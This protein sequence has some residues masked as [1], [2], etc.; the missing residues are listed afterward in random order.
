MTRPPHES[1]PEA[2]PARWLRALLGALVAW[3]AV[4]GALR[5][6]P[7]GHDSFQ[8][9][10][11][12]FYFL[13]EAVERGD[14][15]MWI[16]YMTHGVV[17]TWWYAIVAE[18]LF[19]VFTLL[20]PWL[21][22]T[23]L[24]GYTL[25]SLGFD[26]SVLLLGTWLL[27]R[28]LF[29]RAES[30]AVS[31][32]MI[33]GASVWITQSWHNLHIIY[34]IPLALWLVHRYLDEHR[35]IHLV[36]ALNLLALQAIGNLPYSLPPTTLFVG[37][38][39]IA[40][41]AFEGRA[42]LRPLFA[43]EHLPGLLVAAVVGA[44]GMV[45]VYAMFSQGTREIV[46]LGTGRT[47]DGSVDLRVFLTYGGNTSLRKWFELF[48][49]VSPC[50]DYTLYVG[51]LGVPL[52]VLGA[53]EAGRKNAHVV[54][55]GA[56]ILA[57]S[58]ATP[59][60]TAAYYLWPGMKFFR[61]LA[62]LAPQVKVAVCLLAGIGF[63]RLRRDLGAGAAWSRAT[64]LIVGWCVVQSVVVGTLLIERDLRV[65]LMNNMI[66][67]GGIPANPPALVD[68]YVKA[69]LVE[70]LAMCGLALTA[71]IALRGTPS[72]RR[73]LLPLLFALLA[74]D[75]GLFHVRQTA[76]MSTRL[77]GP[78]REL[79]RATPLPYVARRA[80]TITSAPRWRQWER[81][82]PVRNGAWYWSTGLVTFSDEV[83]ST[84]R[85]DNWL[86]P[87]GRLYNAFLHQPFDR[88]GYR[89]PGLNH[90][91]QFPIAITAPAMRRVFGMEGKLRVFRDAVA[92]L[93]DADIAAVI[94]RDD[95]HGDVL[96]LDDAGGIAPRGE[97][98]SR[99]DALAL[100][101][102]V[103]D[104]DA[105]RIEIR[106]RHVPAGGAWLLYDD[107]WHPGW[108]ASVNG[109][110]TRV[111]RANLAYKSVRL[112]AGDNRVEMRFDLPR[113]RLL[114]RLFA[115]DAGLWIL[116]VMWLYAR[117]LR[118]RADYGQTKTRSSP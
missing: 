92:G 94:Q 112:R 32:V 51:V 104:F 6:F 97:V 3:F 26:L 111:Y 30:A 85:I 93:G 87:V 100:T 7:A 54:I 117:E 20:G 10:T 45:G 75:V 56:V 44:L 114:A 106:V 35:S 31:C 49:G 91:R 64:R 1:E 55:T 86:W 68:A 23:D 48:I 29:A 50:I 11:T 71:V 57:V 88:T 53:L 38:Y 46:H 28:R 110:P 67:P 79:L 25:A 34:A 76:L 82:S 108:S 12:Q 59:V 66:D 102:E 27:A 61:H 69:R 72:R 41:F 115:L 17:A 89:P 47:A 90:I 58:L 4:L 2:R 70:V 101:P 78:A 103:L 80:D 36:A 107:A 15:A 62:L 109:A 98:A 74:L 52:A 37:V 95:Y 77:T 40:W 22:R 16:P 73:A 19:Q 96:L 24:Y 33:L 118:G 14:L 8:V 105:N 21:P 83:A 84:F 42:Q 43:R 63:D 81:V 60:A 65:M 9:M 113:S 116:A 99:D 5:V 39:F 13:D 18:P